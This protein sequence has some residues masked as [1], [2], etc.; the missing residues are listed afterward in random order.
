MV[1]A[2]LIGGEVYVAEDSSGSVVGSAI[3][4]GPDQELL[5]TYVPHFTSEFA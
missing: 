2:G 4:F 3:W 1:K 5:D